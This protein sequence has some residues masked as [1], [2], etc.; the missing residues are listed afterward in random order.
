MCNK[1]FICIPIGFINLIIIKEC[2]NVQAAKQMNILTN[3]RDSQ[4]LTH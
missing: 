3:G 1:W 4:R 2:K